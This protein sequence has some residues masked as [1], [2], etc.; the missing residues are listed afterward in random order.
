MTSAIISFL[1]FF[2]TISAAGGEKLHPLSADIRD[3]VRTIQQ[4]EENK[5]KKAVIYGKLQKFTPWKEGKGANH[6]FWQWEIKFEGGGRIPVVSADKSD[7]ERIIFDEY[8]NENV[9]IFGTVYY[10]IVIGDSNPDH[11]SMTGYRIDADGI[12]VNDGKPLPKHDTC[13]TWRD[14]ESHWNSDAFVEGVVKEYMIPFDGSKLGEEK[15]WDYEIVTPDHYVMPLTS[16]NGNI[17]FKDYL[18]KKVL[19]KAFIKFGIIFGNENTAN[20]TGT[21]IDVYEITEIPDSDPVE[22]ITFELSEFTEEG[23]RERPKGEFSSINYEFCI[24]ASDSIFSYVSS[25]DKSLGV[26]K[27]SK[28]R[29]GCSDKE[30]LCIGSSR[31]AGFKETIKK[32]A[33]LPYIKKISETFWE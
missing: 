23:L 3:T 33:N 2:Y 1:M 20:I 9:I 26:Y 12:M 6:M 4:A 7:G 16:I 32:L 11:Q 29:S 15:I 5:N 27:T 24:P 31:Q 10:G 17:N 25:I 22:K 14:I 13:R 18:G 8:E 21:R 19:V 28:G 30:W